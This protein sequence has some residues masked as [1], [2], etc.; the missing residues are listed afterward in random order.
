MNRI[1]VLF[2]TTVAMFLFCISATQSDSQNSTNFINEQFIRNA[3]QFAS[4]VM[5]LNHRRKFVFPKGTVFTLTPQMTVPVFRHKATK[6]GF[7]S[8]FQGS[9]VFYGKNLAHYNFLKQ[10]VTSNS[11]DIA[12]FSSEVR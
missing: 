6:G 12:Y 3:G 8:D 10:Y 1:T 9:L 7:Q 2:V 11:Y 4:R 5:M